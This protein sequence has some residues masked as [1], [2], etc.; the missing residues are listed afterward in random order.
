MR[1]E[2]GQI[3]TGT[4]GADTG[5]PCTKVRY[6]KARVVLGKQIDSETI[7]CTLVVV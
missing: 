7:S 5:S 2:L 1:T 6:I 4:A 3:Y